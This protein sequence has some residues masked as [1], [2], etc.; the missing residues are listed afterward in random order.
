MLVVDASAKVQVGTERAWQELRKRNI[1][2]LILVNKMDKENI[3]FDEVLEDIREK[4]GKKA[5]PFCWPLGHD[6]GFDGFARVIDRN[7]SIYN[8]KECVDQEIYPDKMDKIDELYAT[9]T[10]SVAETSEELIEKY[11]YVE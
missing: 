1:P 2:T 5:V 4:L 3:K 11:F 10:E 8:G 9:L 7:A 6:E